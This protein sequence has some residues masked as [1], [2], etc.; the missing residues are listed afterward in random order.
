MSVHPSEGALFETHVAPE[1]ADVKI[2]PQYENPASTAANLFPSAE[3]A[4]EF[5]N[6]IGVLF[7]THVV[8][9]LVEV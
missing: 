9:A 7:E 1:S 5:H 2:A 6:R 4:T 3:V 8:P